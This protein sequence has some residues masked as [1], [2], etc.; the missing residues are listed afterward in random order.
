MYSRYEKNKGYNKSIAVNCIE[1]LL[2]TGWANSN[3]L[4]VFFDGWRDDDYEEVVILL[5]V[6]IIEI[7]V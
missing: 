7:K 2:T 5:S 1:K 6:E 3:V 4:L